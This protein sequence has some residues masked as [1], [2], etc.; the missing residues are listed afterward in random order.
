MTKGI[1]LF[2]FDTKD[3]EYHKIL[4]K[5]VHLLKKNLKLEIT[6]VTNFETFKKIKPLG[7]INYKFIEPEVGNKK[8]GLD[9]K[10]VDRHMAYELSPYDTTLVMDIDYFVYT[11]NL[12]QL[13]DTKYDFLIS[14]HAYD[15]TNRDVFDLRRSSMIDMVWATVF[16]FRKTK[17]SKM[18]FDMVK[19]VKKYYGYF[20]DLYRIRDRRFRND[21]AFA[22]ALEQLNGFISYD[23]MPLTL[24][25][26]PPDC[27]IVKM[28]DTGIAWQYDSNLNY[29][30]NQ[31]VHV[32][33]KEIANV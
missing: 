2:C 18:I 6:V 22:I 29:I 12:K 1:L 26:L 4:E 30:E 17:K 25:T 21:Y 9:W 28:S 16:V 14:K 10:N 8:N 31:D 27:K 13:L 19:Y 3:F 33:N 5:C 15:L 23:T 11:D 20:L 24:S 32:L 7:F